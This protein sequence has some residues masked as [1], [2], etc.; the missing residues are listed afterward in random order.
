ML[1]DLYFLQFFLKTFCALCAFR[2]P[3]FCFKFFA[4]FGYPTRGLVG[5]LLRRNSL[6]IRKSTL[7]FLLT[8]LK[9]AHSR[10]YHNTRA[11]RITIH[12]PRS[13]S[14]NTLSYLSFIPPI[15]VQ[16]RITFGPI[17]YCLYIFHCFLLTYISEN[18]L[19]DNYFSC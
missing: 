17:F 16:F 4:K 8:C 1:A 15:F 12:P 11:S 14:S 9:R 5:N 3:A 6:R 13:T 19:L 7:Y 10:S 18:L 2:C